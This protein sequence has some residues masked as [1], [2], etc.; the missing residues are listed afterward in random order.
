MML[1]VWLLCID[2]HLV[3]DRIIHA[4]M[5]INVHVSG[6]RYNNVLCIRVD[7]RFGRH[8]DE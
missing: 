5:I 3:N 6:N 1:P 2:D 4:I 7:V 8:S